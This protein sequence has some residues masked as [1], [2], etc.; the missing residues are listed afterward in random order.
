MFNDY[1]APR[2][3]RKRKV[4]AVLAVGAII[5]GGYMVAKGM[6]QRAGL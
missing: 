1:D 3:S 4:A 5:V 6:I 2:K